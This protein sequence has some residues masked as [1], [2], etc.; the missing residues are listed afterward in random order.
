MAFFAQGVLVTESSIRS[1][2]SEIKTATASHINLWGIDLYNPI[3]L[4]DPETRVLYANVPDSGAVLKQKGA[5][6]TGLLPENINIAN[7]SLHWNG[8]EWAMVMLPLPEDPELCIGLLA[9]ELFH[10]SQPRLG[11]AM[12]SPGKNDHLDAK[13]G[14]IWLRLELE[15]L[16]E[17]LLSQTMDDQAKYIA[18]ALTFRKFRYSIYENSAEN[19]NSLELNEGLAEYTGLMISSSTEEESID[20]LI[21]ML[22]NFY[23]TASFVQSFPYVTIPVYGF[24]LSDIDPG[25]NK[26]ISCTTNLTDFFIQSFHVDIPKD[27]K[28]SVDS[29][30]LFYGEASIR[31]GECLREEKRESKTT[32]LKAMFIEQPH[33]EI[34]VVNMNFAFDPQTIIPLEDHGS[35][36]FTVRV[37]D[38][39]GILSAVKG[40]LISPQFDRVTVGLPTATEGRNIS[41]DGWTLQLN[42]T[43]RME[44]DPGTGNFTLVQGP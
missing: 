39:W 18:H 9:H 20:H 13:E 36:Y 29:I 26:K 2:F 37:S 32:L 31:A 14:R 1:C 40:A 16:T 10:V 42:D 7:T 5:I 28:K 22:E 44:K 8:T 4:V 11:F 15:A 41:G 21:K 27:L 38:T 23:K 33:L 19:E 17:A 43:W 3:L 24:L 12:G 34:R 30:S 25:W 6:F 35:V